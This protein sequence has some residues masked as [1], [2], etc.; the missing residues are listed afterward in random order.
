MALDSREALAVRDQEQERERE[1]RGDQGRERE[2][3]G[4]G[5][6]CPR[7]SARERGRERSAW[8]LTKGVKE[9]GWCMTRDESERAREREGRERGCV[10]FGKTRDRCRA[11]E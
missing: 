7:A 3:V 8:W 2:R 4:A 6:A 9:S 1:V 10:V 11:R 5:S